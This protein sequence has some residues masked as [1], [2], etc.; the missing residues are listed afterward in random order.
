V[1]PVGRGFSLDSEGVRHPRWDFNAITG[2][3]G[4]GLLRAMDSDRPKE[5]QNQCSPVE[6]L[7]RKQGPRSGNAALDPI[8]QTA[9]V[10]L[11]LLDSK[12]K[13]LESRILGHW[14]AVCNA[15]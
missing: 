7:I 15:R 4:N 11:C 14:L 1:E 3:E 5:D 2:A 6:Y 8:S 9:Q 13:R 10:L 12:T